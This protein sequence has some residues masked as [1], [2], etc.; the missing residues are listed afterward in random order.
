VE[1]GRGYVNRTKS[2][3]G[4]RCGGASAKSTLLED[5]NVEAGRGDGGGGR[6]PLAVLLRGGVISG[7]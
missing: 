5:S 3:G 4:G 2:D 7:R 1:G 6:A